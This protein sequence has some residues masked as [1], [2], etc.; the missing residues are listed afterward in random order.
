MSGYKVRGG[1]NALGVKL[2]LAKSSADGW[3]LIKTIRGLVK[4][5]LKMILL[6]YP[7]ERVMEPNFGVGVGSYLFKNFTESTY[8]EIDSKIREQVSRYLPVVTIDNIIF[9]ASGQDFNELYMS[10]RYSIPNIN[11]KDVLE[12]TV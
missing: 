5:N 9:D 6:T 11:V 12:F 10:L 3:Q 8:A 7:G 1:P 4:Q 2:P